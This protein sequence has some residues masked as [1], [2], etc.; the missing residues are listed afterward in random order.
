MNQDEPEDRWYSETELA[1]REDAAFVAGAREMREMIARFV[2]QGGSEIEKRIAISIRANWSP[3]WG[4]DPGCPNGESGHEHHAQESV[5]PQ[6]AALLNDL[7][8]V[9]QELTQAKADLRCAEA[10]LAHPNQQE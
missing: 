6:C 9:K 8:N 4:K 3:Q 7:H 10:A 5:C 2:E 1:D